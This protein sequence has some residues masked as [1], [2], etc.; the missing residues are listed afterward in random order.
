MLRLGK[1]TSTTKESEEES[2]MAKAVF[3]RK[4]VDIT[5]LKSRATRPSEGTQFVIEEIVELAQFEYDNFA[6][7]LLDDHP[8]IEQN[9]HAM[10]V[11]TNGVYH[12]IYIKAEEAKEGI[13]IESEGYS[14]ARYAAYY[15]EP[16]LLTDKLREQIL[17]I[18][19]SGKYNMFDVYGV[20]KEA[21][22]SGYYELA[23][24]I[25]EHKKEYAEF[26]LYGK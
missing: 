11:D 20:Q 1:V 15:S 19:D 8:F 17:D 2:A 7:N 13:L 25:D 23:V 22:I 6:A 26:I 3:L 5:E 4:P 21:Y 12:C 24:F 16:G 10:Y 18:R 9:L 14:Y